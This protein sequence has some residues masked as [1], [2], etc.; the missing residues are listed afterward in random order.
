MNLRIWLVATAACFGWGVMVRAEDVPLRQQAEASLHKAVE[1]FRTQV[2]TEGGYLWRYSADL[3]VREGKKAA[4]ASMVWVEPPGTPSVGMTY[5]LAFEATQDRNYLEAA[6]E[7]A[8]ALVKGQLHS[9]GWDSH[10][11]F[12]PGLRKAYAYRVDGDSNSGRGV[13]TLDD[14]TTQSALRCLM[15]VDR[16]LKFEDQ[17]IHEAAEF[18]LGSLLKAQYPN[19]AWPQRYTAFPDPEKFPLKQANFAN[20]WLRTWPGA[21]YVGHY[22]LNDNSLADTIDTLLEAARIYEAPRYQ[23][24]ALKGGDFLLLAQLPEPQP[25]WAQQYDVNMQPAWANK[26]EPPAVSGL[27]SQQALRILLRLYRET[28]EPK[29][30]DPLPR[31]IAYFRRSLLPD[32]RLARFYEQQ[33]N[34]PLYFTKQYKLTYEDD[35]LPT[36]YKFKVPSD[37]ESIASEHRQ[38]RKLEAAK[39]K[40]PDGGSRPRLTDA[41]AARAKAAITSLD[42]Q[43]RWVEQG[44]MRN[45]GSANVIWQ[46]IDTQTFIS[47]VQVLSNYLTAARQS[48]EGS[49]R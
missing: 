13:T 35:D 43:G 46:V 1:Y 44:R 45:F 23:A 41:L 36:N 3:A 32:G 20:S 34:K 17:P 37:I 24:A 25:A 33:T 6:R 15:G 11:E 39:L 42:E 40:Q 9:G 12:D 49:E 29:Y 30:L 16:A 5:L 2:S 4:T 27:E 47:K 18:A 7:V 14:N 22:T 19:G 8:R 31:A 26:Y 48:S 10:I 21:D 38:I 28:G